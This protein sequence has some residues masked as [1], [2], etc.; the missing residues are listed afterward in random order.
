MAYFWRVWCICC[1]VMYAHS[2]VASTKYKVAMEADDVVTRILFDAISDKF[3]LNV[4]YVYYPSFSAILNAVKTSDADFAANVTFTDERARDFEFTSPTNIEYTYLYSLINA[5]LEQVGIVGVPAGTIY[6]QLIAANYPSIELIEYTGH[7]HAKSLIESHQVDGVVDAINQLKPMLLAG[8]DAQ[9][10]NHQLMI[11]PVSIIS[12]KN[13]HIPLLTKIEDYV[14]SAEVQKQLR[15]AVKQYQFDLRKQ[16]LRQSVIDSN[17]NY[18]KPLRVK[19]EDIGQFAS[20][21]PNGVIS[22]ITADVVQQACA[23]LMLSCDIVSTKGESWESMYH[24]LIDRKIDLLSPMAISESRKNIAYFSAPYYFPKAILVKREGYKEDVYSNVSELIAERIGV[25]RDDFYQELLS[26]RLPNKTLHAFSSDDELFDALLNE[27]IDYLAVSRANFNKR[28]RD[29]DY[30]LPL[31]EESLIGSYYESPIAIGFAKNELGASLAPLFTRALKMIDVERIVSQYD[32]QPNWKATL[33][34][35]QAFSRKSQILFMLVLG[36][37]VVVAMYLHSQ[38]NTDNLTRLKN[39]RA[40]KQKYRSGVNGDETLIYLDV[41][42]F[43]QIND[44][45][46]HE[47]GDQVLRCVSGHIERCWHGSSYR[48]GGDEFVLVGK[49]DPPRLAQLKQRLST[50]PFVSHDRS[51]SFNVSLAFGASVAGRSFMSLQEV[52]HQADLAMYEHK[53]ARSDYVKTKET[54]SKVVCLNQ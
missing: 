49:I 3:G 39:R 17:I 1:F 14:H 37:L 23:I 43:K 31:V 2:A 5:D 21:H 19:I 16:A 4:E 35:E 6:K 30:V 47:V 34:A 51:L 12:P 26:Q 13:T 38:S 10:L 46:G 36:F 40:L 45:Y 22:G 50:I 8:F 18:Q 44:T 48:I 20:Y 29:S 33:Q 7:E 53:H 27:E 9:L 54:R 15:E 11:K 42:K 25:V 41:N 24:D 52:M 28:L 32:Y